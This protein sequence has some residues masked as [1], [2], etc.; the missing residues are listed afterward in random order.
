VDIP[1][2]SFPSG[3]LLMTTA[4]AFL[5]RSL[6]VFQDGGAAVVLDDI[7]FYVGFGIAEAITN[8]FIHFF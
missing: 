8:Q 7:L 2:A 5:L 1:K 4:D 6:Y 3:I